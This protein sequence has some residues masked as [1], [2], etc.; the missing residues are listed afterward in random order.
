MRVAKRQ[1]Q[2]LFQVCTVSILI[3]VSL[4]CNKGE[5]D[6]YAVQ[7]DVLTRDLTLLYEG[8][9]D[10]FIDIVDYAGYNTTEPIHR[11]V[12]KTMLHTNADA[13]RQKGFEKIEATG[14]NSK[15]DS[16][17]TVFYDIVFMDGPRKSHSQDMVFTHG[18]WKLRIGN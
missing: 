3:A 12:L 9:V 8:K 5:E 14:A 16:A 18:R 4:S 10:S 7:K 13:I 11:Y 1:I 6:P 17:A 2:I 15:S